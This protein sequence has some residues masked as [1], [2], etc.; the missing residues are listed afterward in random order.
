M[1]TFTLNA[2]VAVLVIVDPLGNV[3]IFASLLN[4]YSA[5]ERHAMIR[6]ACLVG[7]TI[8]IL[9]TLMGGAILKIFGITIGAFRIAGGLILFGIATSMLAAQKSR[10]RITPGEEV[11]AQSKEDIAIVPLAIPLI[12]GPGAI[13]TVMAL[14]TQ[15]DSYLKTGII[16][17]AILTAGLISYMTYRYASTFLAKIGETGLN[18]MTRLLGLILAV[19]AVQFVING[20]RDSFPEIF[21][22]L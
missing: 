16:I 6:R 10:V 19:M 17:L 12:S 5:P 22:A 9:F 21:K 14:Q 3:P 4:H 15:A 8:L 11:E 7:V 18:I 2:F 13:A 20:I 1:L